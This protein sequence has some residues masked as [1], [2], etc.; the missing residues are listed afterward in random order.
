M[1]NKAEYSYG[2]IQILYTLSN[3]IVYTYKRNIMSYLMRLFQSGS[4]CT[5]K[6]AAPPRALRGSTRTAGHGGLDICEWMGPSWNC[7]Q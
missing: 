1:I 5:S 7:N 6:T 4:K 2:H 3:M